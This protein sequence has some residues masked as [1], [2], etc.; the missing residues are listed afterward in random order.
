MRAMLDPPHADRRQLNNLVATEP[1]LRAP[2]PVAKRVTAPTARIR[3]VIDD[4][5]DLILRLQFATGTPMTGLPTSLT[6][7]PSRRINSFAFS[8]ASDR[9]CARDFGGS[10]DGGFE[11]VR[12][13]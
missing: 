13:S 10:I 7:P 9:L 3:V 6:L 11:L 4:L 8:R 1:S 12:E 5:I 2:L